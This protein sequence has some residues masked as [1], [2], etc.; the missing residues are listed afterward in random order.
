MRLAAS[1]ARERLGRAEIPY[2]SGA[3]NEPS[4]RTAISAGFHCCRE[5]FDADVCANP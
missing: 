5:L 3:A 2:Y 1:Y 4:E